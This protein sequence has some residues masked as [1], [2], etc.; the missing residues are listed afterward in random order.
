[1]D[2]YVDDDLNNR[3]KFFDGLSIDVILLIDD[4]VLVLCGIVEFVFSVW[5]S[6]LN[7][8]VGFVFC[9]YWIK[10]MVRMFLNLIVF[11]RVIVFDVCFIVSFVYLEYYNMFVVGRIERSFV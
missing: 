3:F 10:V 2:I 4:D 5:M 7:S 9:M 6:V 1:M 11:I 8:M